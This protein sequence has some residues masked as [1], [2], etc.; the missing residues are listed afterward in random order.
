MTAQ[1]HLGNNY[2]TQLWKHY[3]YAFILSLKIQESAYA[4]GNNPSVYIIQSKQSWWREF[5]RESREE[6][7]PA[8]PQIERRQSWHTMLCYAGRK[9]LSNTLHDATG[10][11]RIPA[12]RPM[13]NSY[14]QW[15]N[16]KY[17]NL[18]ELCLVCSARTIS[19]SSSLQRR[20]RLITRAS[21]SYQLL[22]VP[23]LFGFAID[24]ILGHN[25]QRILVNAPVVA[26]HK[27]ST[28]HSG[29]W[30]GLGAPSRKITSWINMHFVHRSLP[31]ICKG[32][33][34]DGGQRRDRH[35]GWRAQRSSLH[36]CHLDD[37]CSSL[38]PLQRSAFSTV[39]EGQSW[40]QEIWAHQ[41]TLHFLLQW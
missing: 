12:V 13:P 11:R 19:S 39:S 38:H 36:P 4:R 34:L 5:G 1:R 41:Y 18:C 15:M 33:V 2:H 25:L 26:G 14:K 20:C 9:Y 24:L 32:Y 31:L 17:N 10:H 40:M 16:A 28:T 3:L 6:T 22:H 21:D 8:S 37:W 7:Q 29:T 35:A 30:Q 27:M 23:V